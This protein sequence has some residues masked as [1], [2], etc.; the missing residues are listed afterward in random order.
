MGVSE[1]PDVTANPAATSAII[2][3]RDR[4]CRTT[5]GPR[6]VTTTGCLQKGHSDSLTRMCRRQDGQRPSAVMT[7][8]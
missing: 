1:Q 2:A 7:A 5:N 3:E 8:E 6:G 4:S